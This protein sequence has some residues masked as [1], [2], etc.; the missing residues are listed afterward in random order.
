LADCPTNELARW[1]PNSSEDG[2]RL[3]WLGLFNAFM[4]IES[5]VA[6]EATRSFTIMYFEANKTNY[7]QA[8]YNRQEPNGSLIELLNVF[9]ALLNEPALDRK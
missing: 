7:K 8:V 6:D 4:P 2:Q 3:C 5:S 9:R 1:T